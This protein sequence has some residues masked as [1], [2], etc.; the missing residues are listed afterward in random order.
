MS[1]LLKA[2]GCMAVA[3]LMGTVL[4][5]AAILLSIAVYAAF[6]AYRARYVNRRICR[7][8]ISPTSK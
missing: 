3:Y 2:L 5:P 7:R 6:L 1:N 4:P 8:I